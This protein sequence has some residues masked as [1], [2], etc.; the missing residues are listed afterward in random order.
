MCSLRVLKV[1][2]ARRA[3]HKQ[4]SRLPA[5]A[6]RSP[7]PLLMAPC[8]WGRAA[9]GSDGVPYRPC[10]SFSTHR[11]GE[12]GPRKAGDLHR[13]AADPWFP[14]PVSPGAP[15]V[16]ALS[17]TRPR[18]SGPR[19][20]DPCP[21]TQLC[22]LVLSSSTQ[23]FRVPTLCQTTCSVPQ[24]GTGGGTGHRRPL[25]DAGEKHGAA[26]CA[27]RPGVFPGD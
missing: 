27:L 22:S 20:S 7:A 10:T 14:D 25:E 4:G 12:G 3:E 8:F 1:L 11:G 2:G 6:H 16:S 26:S 5:A 18:L 23:G 24:T 13:V 19:R 17:P 15:P 21:P 9:G